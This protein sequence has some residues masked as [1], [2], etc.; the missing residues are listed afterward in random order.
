MEAIIS[1]IRKLLALSG[2]PNEHEA[3]LAAAKAQELLSQY[4][5]TL[6]EIDIKQSGV[7]SS[8]VKITTRTPL[9]VW[10]LS[11]GVASSFDCGVYKKGD[12]VVFI[13]MEKDSEVASWMFKYLYETVFKCAT[14]Y[15]SNLSGDKPLARKSFSVGMA[16]RLTARLKERKTTLDQETGQFAL[17]PVKNALVEKEMDKLNLRS[18]TPKIDIEK[19]HFTNGTSKGDQVSLNTPIG[20]NNVCNRIG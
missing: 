1:R 19:S 10:E 4:N 3:A 11:S 17:V 8:E 7:T 5:L 13:G 9:W 20:A 12:K 14:E 2:S 15:I 6:S 16:Y 18:T